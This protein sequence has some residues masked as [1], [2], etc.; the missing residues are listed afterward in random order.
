MKAQNSGVW[1]GAP[2]RWSRCHGELFTSWLS[3]VHS[4]IRRLRPQVIYSPSRG[5]SIFALGVA[6]KINGLYCLANHTSRLPMRGRRNPSLLRLAIR[7]LFA[8]YPPTCFGQMPR[9]RDGR[10][11]MSL[12]RLQS[13]IQHQR[14]G[15]VSL[16][17]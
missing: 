4:L 13:L 2:G 15:A 12:G 1:G 7:L 5:M 17:C 10:F 6:I 16:R 11:P 9:N 8:E 3:F 14:V